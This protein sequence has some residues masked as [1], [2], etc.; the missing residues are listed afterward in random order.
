ML[1]PLVLLGCDKG[2]EGGDEHGDQ[3]TEHAT[4]T[5]G[6]TADTHGDTE[7]GETG[8]A[9]CAAE[10]RDDD[11]A[12]GLSKSG[13]LIQA[14]FVLADPAPPI[15]SDNTWVLSFSDLE[16]QPLAELDIVALPMM[17]DHGHGTP[18]A[19]VVTALDTPGQYEITPVN[20][21]MAGYWQITFDVTLPND[22]GQDSVMFGFCVE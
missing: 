14:A 7:T 2:D 17:P 22:G 5:H 3:T 16:G 10:T 11:F 18:I 4:D 12:I 21:F 9:D 1:L 8:A 13:P 6:E 15:K 20:L 19:A